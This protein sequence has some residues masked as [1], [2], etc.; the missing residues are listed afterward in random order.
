M[1]IIFVRTKKNREMK[2]EGKLSELFGKLSI[3]KESVIVVRKGIVITPDTN[4]KNHDEI[5]I[6]PVISGG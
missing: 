1:K 4:L 5:I 3:N 6:L 2:F